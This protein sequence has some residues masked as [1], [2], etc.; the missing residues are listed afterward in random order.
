[1]SFVV[2]IK[3]FYSFLFNFVNSII[4]GY[5]LGLLA[6]IIPKSS[7]IKEIRPINTHLGPIAHLGDLYFQGYS[8]M[9]NP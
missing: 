2:Y 9:Q 1:M 6:A 3:H 5:Y 7:W 8:L 4:L